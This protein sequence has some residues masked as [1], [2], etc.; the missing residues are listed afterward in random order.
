MIF[1]FNYFYKFSELNKAIAILMSSISV[2]KLF[3]NR[4]DYRAE[5]LFTDWIIYI[6]NENNLNSDLLINLHYKIN[7]AYEKFKLLS[8]NQ[9]KVNLDIYEKLEIK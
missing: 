1:H 7:E 9:E 8:P 5:Q 3:S 4:F 6:Q 2:L